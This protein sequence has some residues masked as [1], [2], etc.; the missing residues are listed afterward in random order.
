MSK[1]KWFYKSGTY[2]Y[3]FLIYCNDFFSVKK[4]ICIN[5]MCFCKAIPKNNLLYS[6]KKPPTKHNVLV[7]SQLTLCMKNIDPFVH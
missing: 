3:K 1:K 5:R 2:L 6:V 7:N 4:T